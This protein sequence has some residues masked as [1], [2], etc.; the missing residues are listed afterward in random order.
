MTVGNGLECPNPQVSIH[1]IFGN[2][3]FIVLV[4]YGRCILMK[5]VQRIPFTKFLDGSYKIKPVPRKKKTR[6]YSIIYV[7][8]AAFIDPT[9][10]TIGA[11]VLSAAIAEKVLD[12][13]GFHDLVSRIERVRSVVLPLTVVGALTYVLLQ[14]L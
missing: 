4:I 14:I 9:I 3:G 6:A 1:A 10:C 5:N 8:P 11:I 7:N 2:N 13:C 12:A